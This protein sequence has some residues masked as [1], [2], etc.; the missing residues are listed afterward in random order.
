M[1]AAVI[2][3]ADRWRGL[4]VGEF[5]RRQL[6]A[7]RAEL[8]RAHTERTAPAVKATSSASPVSYPARLGLDHPAVST[9]QAAHE[10][11]CKIAGCRKVAGGSAW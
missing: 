6:K 11:Q 9:S 1:H 8:D 3:A 5:E 7:I 10:A 2:R 4:T